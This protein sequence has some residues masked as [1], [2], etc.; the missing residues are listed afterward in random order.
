MR[1]IAPP[2]PYGVAGTRAWLEAVGRACGRGAALRRAWRRAER[3]HA[4]AREGLRRECAE[5]RLGFVVGPAQVAALFDPLEMAGIPALDVAI[6]LGFGIDLLVFAAGDGAAPETAIPPG[7]AEA[8]DLYRFRDREALRALLRDTPCAAVYSDLHAD[9]R[10]TGAGKTPF[11][12]QAF[13]PGLAGALRTGER[14]LGA[15]RLPF[16][17]KYAAHG[18]PPSCRPRGRA[19]GHRGADRP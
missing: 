10:I 6:D 2:P 14:L 9:E 1:T 8:V 13:E 17:R 5:F 12:L 18:R 3:D 11:S 16:Y 19:G 15:C 4:A 7:L